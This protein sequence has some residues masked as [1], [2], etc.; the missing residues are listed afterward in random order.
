[1]SILNRNNKI[2]KA[3][4]EKGEELLLLILSLSQNTLYLIALVI[5]QYYAQE[6]IIRY[7]LAEKLNLYL[8]L[9]IRFIFAGSTLI[10]VL[11]KIWKNLAIAFY[12][13][14]KTIEEKKDNS[15]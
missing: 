4:K 8:L 11:L 3:L 12:Q 9:C 2:V 14:R 6:I 13:T 7:N 5:I 15:P 10:L 1:M